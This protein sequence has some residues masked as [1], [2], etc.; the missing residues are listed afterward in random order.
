[1]D[2]QTYIEVDPDVKLVMEFMQRNMEADKLRGVAE[3]LHICASAIWGRYLYE[4]IHPMCLRE[5]PISVLL[6]S[7]DKCQRI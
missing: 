1:M 2:N 3:A 4:P 7:N 5:P 6:N